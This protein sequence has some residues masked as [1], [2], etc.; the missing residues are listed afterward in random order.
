MK[1]KIAVLLS[2]LAR[3][4]EENFKFLKN[5]FKDYDFK[6]L[7]LIWKNQKNLDSF[8]RIYFLEDIKEIEQNNWSYEIS[9]IKYVFGEEN[10]SYKL[11]NIFHM[12]HSIE[13]NTK[14]LENY[15]IKNNINFD[16]VCRFRGDLYSKSKNF[17]ISKYINKIN[18]N[19]I[20]FPENFHSRGLNDLFFITNFKT[21]LK[22]KEC[23]EYLKIF[24]NES[25]PL[26]SEYFF[27]HFIRNKSIKIKIIKNFKVNLFGEE[28]KSHENY[29][30]QPTKKAYIPLI[31]KIH[32]K[33]IKYKLRFLK[34]FNF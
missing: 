20:I 6:I 32:L 10:R 17:D 11:E 26:S 31:D 2:G 21:F 22:F 4:E 19:E 14:Y 15:S 7:P 23:I 3:C 5:L 1:K 24:I 30:L 25:R 9:K 18:N 29:T 16:Y 13:E 27:Y 8:K 12:W 33:Y 34:K 28:N